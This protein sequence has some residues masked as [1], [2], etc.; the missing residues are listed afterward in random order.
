MQSVLRVDTHNLSCD[1]KNV[2]VC[3]VATSQQRNLPIKP[4]KSHSSD[5]IVTTYSRSG[6][7]RGNLIGKFLYAMMMLP[8]KNNAHE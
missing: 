5:T 6:R 2:L 4:Q 8:G 3:A 7:K 1:K